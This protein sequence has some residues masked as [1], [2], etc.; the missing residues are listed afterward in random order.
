MH[1]AQHKLTGSPGAL[2]ERAFGKTTFFQPKLTV[3]QPNDVYE[4]EA[5]AMADRVM[6]M[7][8]PLGNDASFFKPL[9]TS[10]QRK[11]Q[12]CEEEEKVHRKESSDAETKG[13]HELDNYVGS[14]GASGQPMPESS[15]RFFEPRFGQD[16]SNVRIHTDSVAAKSAQSINALAY[17]T[18]NNIVFNSGQYAPESDSGKKL[19]AHELTHVVQ[20]GEGVVRRYGHDKFCSEDKHL[21]PFIWPGHAAAVGMLTRVLAAFKAK[22]PRLS[23]LIPKYFGKDGMANI[24]EIEAH[25]N[26]INDKLNADYL[27]HCNDGA[28]ANPAIG[29]CNGATRARTDI[30]FFP[31]YNIMLCFDMINPTWTATDV[32]ALMIHENYHRAYG[33][34]THVWGLPGNPPDCTSGSPE[35]MQLLLDNPDS[36]SCMA[37]HF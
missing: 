21:K 36:Y 37:R 23:T 15:R 19:M 28:N 26:K 25:Y 9:A 33:G 10:V 11:C 29:K 32:G 35:T 18:S 27:Y 6:R 20:Q 30:D 2:Q 1:T 12:H 13:G 34:S 4:Q 24:S 16:F 31:T 14:L 5:D 22:D 7:A 3:N 8:D 17:T